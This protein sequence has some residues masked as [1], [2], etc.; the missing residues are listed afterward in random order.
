MRRLWAG[1]VARI[2]HGSRILH[3]KYRMLEFLGEDCDWRGQMGR[4]AGNTPTSRGAR[5]ARAGSRAHAARAGSQALAPTRP[6]PATR[7]S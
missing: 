2:L 4:R 5:A 7:P 6:E 3:A 1:G